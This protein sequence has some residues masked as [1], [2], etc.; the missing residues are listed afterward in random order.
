MG[1]SDM[2][3]RDLE[4]HLV[5]AV[6]RAG[7]EAYKWVSPGRRGVPDRLVVLPGGRV[8][9]VEVKRPGG[10]GVLSALQRIEC[11]R[12]RELGVEVRVIDSVEAIAQLLELDA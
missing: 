8:V 3:E 6:K 10:G 11:G 5:R 12:L 4:R 2:L 1:Y 9:G 7:G